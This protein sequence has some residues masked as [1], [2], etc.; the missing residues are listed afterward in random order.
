MAGIALIV[1]EERLGGIAGAF[2]DKQGRPCRA[3]KG[4]AAHA[5]IEELRDILAL[6]GG[7]PISDDTTIVAFGE[8][9][10]WA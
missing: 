1:D 7:M 8:S 10:Q 9:L 5:A 4:L 3:D 6:L 2:F